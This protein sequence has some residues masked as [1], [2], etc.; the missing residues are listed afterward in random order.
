MSGSHLFL[1]WENCGYIDREEQVRGW[2]GREVIASIAHC[3]GEC[4]EGF[5]LSIERFAA[6]GKPSLQ[7]KVLF[8]WLSSFL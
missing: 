5:L 2:E 1:L 3:P 6:M 7:G 4:S 8:I